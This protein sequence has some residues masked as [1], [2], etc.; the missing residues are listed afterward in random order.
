[1][2]RE[3]PETKFRVIP[4]GVDLGFF[5]PS[6]PSPEKNTMVFTGAMNYYPNNHGILFFLDEIFPRI[7]T[8]T[9]D[10]RIFVVG[11]S[12]SKRLM[13]RASQ[14]VI[15]SGFVDDVRPYIARA[16]VC[17]IP[18][19]IGGGTRLK[20]LEA[21]AM[22]RPI[23]ST[24]LGCEGIHLKHEE[25]ALFADTPEEFATAVVRLFGDSD[26]RSKLAE[27]AYASVTA[28]YDWSAIGEQLESVHQSLAQQN[29][30]EEVPGALVG[31]N[32]VAQNT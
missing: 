7:L 17:V 18:L 30:R 11:S 16:N 10:A 5:S 14:N 29:L 25:S 23:V 12:P 28:H 24:T 6:P 22:K 27:N 13:K 1:M 32:S 26:L 2:K 31:S 9:P 15:I 19:L 4:N 20:A 8:R 21:M 3:L